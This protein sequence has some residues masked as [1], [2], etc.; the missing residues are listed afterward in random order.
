MKTTH[1][2]FIKY[3]AFFVGLSTL[4]FIASIVLMATKG[5]NYGIDFKGG[6]K[7]AYKFVEPVHESQV[8]KA[9]ADT[10][11][12]DASV[13]RFGE[14]SENRMSIKVALPEEHAQIGAEIT[15]ALEKSFGPGKVRLEQEESVGP[16]VGKEMRK[17]AWLTIIFSWV[18]MLIYIGYRFDFLY[19]PGAIISLMHDTV[20]TLGIF[21]LLGKEVNLTILA[22]ILTLIGYSI[23][24]TIVVFDRIRENGARISREAIRSV[25]NESIN[26]TL[27]RTIITALTVFIVVVVLFFKGG[28]T[29]H[30]FAFTMI[31]GVLIGTYSSIF[32]AS[33]FY[34]W[35]Y[36]GWPTIRKVWAKR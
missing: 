29:L 10:E 34:I 1:I 17:K 33:P 36:L 3:Q 21:S 4:V 19:A 11:F 9:L 27:S 28:G 32:V 16:R 2:P 8:R 35:L 14:A 31:V 12:A 13:V 23:N 20:I 30:D 15:A 7:L 5:F 18:M 26:S 25:V 22:A 24:D 6:A